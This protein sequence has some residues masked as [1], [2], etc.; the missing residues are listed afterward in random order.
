MAIGDEVPPNRALITNDARGAKRDNKQPEMYIIADIK[1]KAHGG[2]CAKHAGSE[3]MVKAMP[4]D[5]KYQSK[6]T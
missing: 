6:Q 1:M 5:P 3:T 4:T 2:W